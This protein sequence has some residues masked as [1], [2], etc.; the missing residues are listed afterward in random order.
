[1][2]YISRHL[3]QRRQERQ[4]G[5]EREQE[6]KEDD[7]RTVNQNNTSPFTPSYRRPAAPCRTG[8]PPLRSCA[9]PAS[10]KT[11]SAVCTS[12]FAPN[13]VERS[14]TEI[15]NAIARGVTT[16]TPLEH[17]P[18][19]PRK[20]EIPARKETKRKKRKE[21]KRKEKEREGP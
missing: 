12:I 14:N 4:E 2:P 9:P 1:M 13:A 8:V 3:A 10:Q 18:D 7:A 5:G 15:S 11:W 16:V 21:K 17:T 6:G 19:T 20:R